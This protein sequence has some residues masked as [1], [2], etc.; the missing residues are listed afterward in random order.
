M[1]VSFREAMNWLHTW[2][3]VVLGALLFAIFWMGTL[4]V[5]DREIDRWMM[6]MTRLAALSTPVS[7]DAV[8]PAAEQLAVSAG[9]NQWYALPPTARVPTV[10]IGYRQASGIAVRHANPNTGALLPDAGTW[11]GTRFIFPFHYSLH[12]KLW[13]LGSWLVGFAG[14]AMFA[15][16]ITGTII[17]VRMFREFFVFRPSRKAGRGVLDLHNL[18]GVLGLPFH[19]MIT[20]SGMIIFFAIYFPSAWHAPFQGNRQAFQREA[21][22]HYTRP[23]AKIPGQLASLDAMV[24]QAAQQ[25]GG[26][27]AYFIRVWHPGDANA[28]VE[29]RRAY[30]NAVTMHLDVMY[31]DG[32]SGQLLD[33]F[34]AA[35][36]LTA[37]RF[38]SGLHFIQYRH[39]TLRWLYFALGLLGCGLIATGFLFWI[40]SRR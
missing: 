40:E 22:G 25:W 24:A 21:Y 7:I 2:A 23:P 13:D 4:S 39:W 26:D 31:F 3:G 33:S 32:A 30:E 20:L 19:L 27:P 8:R 11:A 17:H 18:A 34:V 16:L 5:F 36:V 38:I 9:S 6:P 37:Q 10:E 28:Y 14:M 1:G 12:L 35:P 15:L 29:V